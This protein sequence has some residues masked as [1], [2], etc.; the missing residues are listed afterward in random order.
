[1][2]YLPVL[3]H[4]ALTHYFPPPAGVAALS[5]PSGQLKDREHPLNPFSGGLKEPRRGPPSP[6]PEPCIMGG[7]PPLKL[8]R[9]SDT[10]KPKGKRPCKTKHTS[11][12]EKRK[13]AAAPGPGLRAAADPAAA[14]DEKVSA[15]GMSGEP[16]TV[17]LLAPLI[18]QLGRGGRGRDGGRKYVYN[19]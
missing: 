5:L 16:V 2:Q 11:H 18:M 12:R 14:E 6:A 8:R 13:E 7:T 19:V 3:F 4:R 9:H 10:D 1:M 15:D 17:C